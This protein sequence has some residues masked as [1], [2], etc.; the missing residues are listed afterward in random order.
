M[1]GFNA[2]TSHLSLAELRERDGKDK[3][4]RELRESLKYLT[5]Q[6]AA[7]MLVKYCE[8]YAPETWNTR[9]RGPSFVRNYETGVVVPFAKLNTN[10]NVS[11]HLL[12]EKASNAYATI[13]GVD[14]PYASD[15]EFKITAPD[16]TT[17]SGL[18][19]KLSRKPAY[20]H[21]TLW[22]DSLILLTPYQMLGLTYG[23]D[24]DNV[25]KIKEALGNHVPALFWQ[26]PIPVITQNK[27]TWWRAGSLGYYSSIH[28][29]LPYKGNAALYALY[30]D[31]SYPR[32]M[33][34]M[35][36]I[37]ILAQQDGLKEWV[38]FKEG[39]RGKICGRRVLQRNLLSR[40]FSM[41]CRTF[42]M[43]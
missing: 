7:M 37:C 33:D 12:E 34:S 27:D 9:P 26:Q 40:Y 18:L 16:F 19:G 35:N 10:T 36:H 38:E 4:R 25:I 22:P 39:G 15:F 41:R 3:Y 31:G 5:A 28:R 1:Q 2:Y 6:N 11:F 8:Y 13:S 17:V 32:Q 20:T 30:K 23:K 14:I 43:G 24:L 42:W 21:I 29:P